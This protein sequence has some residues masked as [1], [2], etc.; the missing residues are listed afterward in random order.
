MQCKNAVLVAFEREQQTDNKLVNDIVTFEENKE[1]P[2]LKI[3]SRKVPL[4]QRTGTVPMKVKNKHCPFQKKNSWMPHRKSL[5][6]VTQ[7]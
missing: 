5:R 7:S 4:N 3:S 1:S 6:K 2:N